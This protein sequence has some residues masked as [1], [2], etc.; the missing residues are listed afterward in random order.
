MS[1]FG[2]AQFGSSQF[3]A[4][5]IVNSAI[6]KSEIIPFDAK[7]AIKEFLDDSFDNLWVNIEDILNL[8]PPVDL[9][10]NW[11]LVIEL[12]NTLLCSIQ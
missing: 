6:E 3:G 7:R 12:V 1:Q 4:S 9:L 2:S 11:D 10:D 8:D 5:E